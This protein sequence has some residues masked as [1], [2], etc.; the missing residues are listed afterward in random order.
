MPGKEYRLG[1][2]IRASSIM[3][4]NRNVITQGQSDEAIAG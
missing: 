2:K 1:S 4:V 3:E